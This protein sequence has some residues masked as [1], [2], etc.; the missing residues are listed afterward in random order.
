MIEDSYPFRFVHRHRDCGNGILYIDVYRFKSTKSNLIYFVNVERYDYNMYAVKFYQ[1]NHKLSPKKYQILSNTFE[2][3]RMIYTCMNVM[4]SVFAEN[5]RASFGFIG[6]NCEG[7]DTANTKRYRVY[8][9]IVATKISTEQFKHIENVEKSAY[10][11]IN[12]SELAKHPDL[13]DRIEE[14][15]VELYDFFE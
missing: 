2:P 15:F 6:A 11:L 13:I 9:K 12:R 10:M 3:R 8:N 14:A 5:P 4:L 1:K 7:E